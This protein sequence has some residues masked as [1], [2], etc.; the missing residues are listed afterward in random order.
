MS[1]KTSPAKKAVKVK[2]LPAKKTVKGGLR[3]PMSM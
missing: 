3:P 1:K 2:D